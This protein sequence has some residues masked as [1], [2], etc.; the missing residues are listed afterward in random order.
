MARRHRTG[1]GFDKDTWIAL[2]TCVVCLAIALSFTLYAGLVWF[3]QHYE[4]AFASDWES[5]HAI[6][7]GRVTRALIWLLILDLAFAST[8]VAGYLRP[9]S[10]KYGRR[11]AFRNSVTDFFDTIAN[12]RWWSHR[13]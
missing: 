1:N 11:R 12:N 5:M 8:V 7:P 6:P 3:V 13:K 9:A 2:I 4:P 10:L